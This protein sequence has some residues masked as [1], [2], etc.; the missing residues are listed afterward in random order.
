MSNYAP[1]L[2]RIGYYTKDSFLMNVAKASIVGRSESFPG[3]HMNTAR[4]TAY[5]KADFP[6]HE[7]KDQSVNSFHYNH[8]LPMASL[9]VDYMVSDAF[10]K[11]N[12][13]IDF[14]SEYIEGY[15]YLQNKFYGAGKGRFFKAAGVQLWMPSRLLNI[16]DIAL[17]Y[18]SAKKNDTLFLAF[19][20][21]SP[22]AVTTRVTVNPA[23]VACSQQA[24]LRLLSHSGKILPLGDSSFLLTVPARGLAA[25]AVS[26]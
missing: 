1:W 17:N 14:P 22:A 10:V 4:T 18:I 23:L 3:Y 11:S 5:E 13:Q 7:H 19:M 24:G 26:G 6:L 15:A 8:I 16:E 20:N 25:V 2:L 12:G 9:F 21:Q